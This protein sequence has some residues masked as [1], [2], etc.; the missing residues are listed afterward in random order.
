MAAPAEREPA[1]V[2]PGGGWVAG[3]GEGQCLPR[4]L[5]TTGHA[6]L[7]SSPPAAGTAQCG[8]VCYNTATQCCADSATSTVGDFFN[9]GCYAGS[10]C[11]LDYKLSTGTII[12]IVGEHRQSQLSL[13]DALRA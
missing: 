6:S 7:P 12:S 10:F 13:P 8:R 5:L 9:G 11:R 2:S 4:A 1:P 3:V